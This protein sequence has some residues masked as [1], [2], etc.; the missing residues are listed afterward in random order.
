MATQPG[1]K[2]EIYLY[3]LVDPQTGNQTG[4]PNLDRSGAIQ[5]AD[6][7]GSKLVAYPIAFIYDGRVA[8]SAPYNP[9]NPGN[10]LQW[11]PG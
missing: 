8:G 10:P 11:P 9:A 4:A 3:V 2:Q 1:D 5:R 6:Q 7:T